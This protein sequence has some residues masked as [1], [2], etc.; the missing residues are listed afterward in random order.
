MAR[1]ATRGGIDGAAPARRRGWP[2]PP[3]IVRRAATNRIVRRYR[4]VRE[5]QGQAGVGRLPR[6]R[7]REAAASAPRTDG[8]KKQT[9]TPALS[10]ALSDEVARQDRRGL[11]VAC[12]PGERRTWTAMIAD[13]GRPDCEEKYCGR[14]LLLQ[15]IRLEGY[16][17][18]L[19]DRMWID[20]AEW[21]PKD[22]CQGDLL[23]FDAGV[24][25][26]PV[27]YKENNWGH[28]EPSVRSALGFI[29]PAAATE[30]SSANLQSEMRLLNWMMEL[31][32]EICAR[33]TRELEGNLRWNQ[34]Q[35]KAR[36]GRTA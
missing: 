8:M 34:A 4:A 13:D 36:R 21:V 24:D 26:F 22:I 12:P 15:D 10:D 7:A 35:W 31:S 9:L 33:R 16:P 19:A 30:D 29:R 6:C 3:R 32:L 11:H 27:G 14:P 5:L 23:R 17:V 25:C 2:S 20:W 28:I 1:R 18:V